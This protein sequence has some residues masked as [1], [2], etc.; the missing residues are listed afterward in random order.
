[1]GD[2]TERTPGLLLANLRESYQ[3]GGLSEADCGTNPISLFARWFGEAQAAGLREPN[4]MTL[5][6]AT[7]DGRPSARVVL[8]KELSEDEFV[9]YTNY[10]SRKGRDIETNPNVALSFFWN[11]LERQVRVEG[12]AE[13]VSPETS[14]FYY[15]SRP[16]GSRLGAWASPQSQPVKDREEL[17]SKLAALDAQYPDGNVP[18]PEFWGGYSVVPT[19]L[20]FWQGRPNRLHDRIL[21]SR[22]L[23]TGESAGGWTR[24]RLA[25]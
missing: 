19:S 15:Q 25:P 22:S 9:F 3:R 21:F 11:E 5:A 8:L 7:R 18:M 17:E 24:V 16:R 2:F 4:A 12:R 20:E 13:R 14:E 10:Q 1:M 6:T 23:G